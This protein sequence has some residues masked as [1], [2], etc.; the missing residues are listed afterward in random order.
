MFDEQ[1]TRALNRGVQLAILAII[2]EDEVS[3]EAVFRMF[4]DSFRPSID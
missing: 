3:L 1:K 4:W 2:E